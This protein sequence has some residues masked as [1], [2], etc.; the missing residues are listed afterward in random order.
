MSRPP[1]WRPSCF[2]SS[3]RARTP[4]LAVRRHPSVEIARD[5]E[6]VRVGSLTAETLQR[7]RRRPVRVD[8]AAVGAGQQGGRH[9]HRRLRL[10]ARHRPHPQGDRHARTSRRRPRVQHDRHRVVVR[11]HVRRPAGAP[12]PAARRPARHRPVRTGPTAPG[13]R[14]CEEPYADAAAACGA[15]LGDRADDYTT[16]LSADDL[17]AVIAQLGL[18]KVDV[19]GDSYGTFFTQ[20]FVGRHPDLIRTVVLDASY[21]TYGE[22]GVVPDAGGRDAP[23]LRHG[24]RAVGALPD[25]RR[26]VRADAR[27]GAGPGAQAPVARPLARRR[28]Q[29]GAGGG[30]RPHARRRGVR[31]DVHARRST[32]S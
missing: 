6:P 10:P 26:R 12:Q 11:R 19:Y 15:A 31:R 17:A 25:R 16:A 21:P 32:A 1:C 8:R 5:A 20:V 30:G 24:L 29:A 9:D 14:T 23:R 18:G 28:R 22:N 4:A 13:C 27:A 2:R 3:P 7:P